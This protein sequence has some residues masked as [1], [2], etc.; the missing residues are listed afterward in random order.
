MTATCAPA[1]L[2]RAVREAARGKRGRRDVAAFL[3]D[4]EA[5]VARLAATLAQATWRPSPIEVMEIRDPKPRVI[6]RPSFED[7][8]VHRA[9]VDALD[10][11]WASRIAPGDVAC[12]PGHG[13][14]RAVLRIAD[15]M[16]RH[17]FVVHLDVRAYFPSIDHEHLDRALAR[18]VRDP[19]WS[20]LCMRLCAQ[21][22]PLYA[23]PE[24]RAH[25]RLTADWPPPGR[26]LP[27]GT[28]LSQYLAAHVYLNAFDHWVARELRVGAY[29]RYVDDLFVFGDRRADLRAW[30]RAIAE[31]LLAH[32]GL[33]LKYPEARILSCAGHVDALGYRLGRHERTPLPAVARRLSRRT[34][35]CLRGRSRVDFERSLNGFAG[36]MLF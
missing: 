16:R 4:G 31:W 23:R 34:E 9:M 33:R 28:S 14:H 2:M 18:R 13:T 19:A 24:V 3:L 15:A 27:I 35:D 30:R 10:V 25:A 12:R 6:A 21:G 22:P 5:H 1:A 11:A 20:R 17:R 36:H 32:R 8:V 7:R 29:Q 26:G